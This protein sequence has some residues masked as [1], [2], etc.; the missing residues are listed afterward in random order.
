L[1]MG[2]ARTTDESAAKLTEVMDKGAIVGTADYISPEQAMSGNVDIR[3]DIYSLG[4]TF[5][6]L[7]TGQP[8]FGGNTTQK[9]IQHQLKDAPSL[10]NLDKTFPP[11]LSAIVTKMLAKKAEQR[12]QTPADVIKAV[13][14]WLPQQAGARLSAAISG[15]DLASSTDMQTT[16]S[17]IAN[18]STK[19]LGSRSN[20]LRIVARGSANKWLWPTMAGSALRL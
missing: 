5:F 10:T 19:R 8:P 1:D 15:T 4:A 2:L 9:L 16:L 11:G 3:S 6:A 13:A 14:G 18:G 17:E 12:F 20:L 7:V